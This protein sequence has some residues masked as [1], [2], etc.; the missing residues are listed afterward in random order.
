MNL[1]LADKDINQLQRTRLQSITDQTCK[2]FFSVWKQ[3]PSSFF[4]LPD[5]NGV[6]CIKSQLTLPNFLSK[7][8]L[9]VARVSNRWGRHVGGDTFRKWGVRLRV[10]KRHGRDSRA[11]CQCKSQPKP[12]NKPTTWNNRPKQGAANSQCGCARQR[13]TVDWRV[14]DYLSLSF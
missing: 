5:L 6:W 7:E 12:T 3:F 2:N 11:T 9:N 1:P 4:F 13:S 14:R 8:F 10:L